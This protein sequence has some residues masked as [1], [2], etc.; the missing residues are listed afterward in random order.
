MTPE[1]KQVGFAYPTSNTAMRFGFGKIGCYFVLFL[2]ADR[3]RYSCRRDVAFATQEEAF[4]YAD[5]QPE[6]Y[7]H[8]SLRPDGSRPWLKTA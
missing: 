8:F 4:S 5:Q 7:D 1:T 6:P 3:Q 2:T